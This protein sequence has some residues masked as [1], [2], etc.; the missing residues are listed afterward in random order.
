[1]T[2]IRDPNTQQGA[3][4]NTRGQLESASTVQDITALISEEDGEMY[5]LV[6]EYTTAQNDDEVIYLQN[7]SNKSLHIARII[8]AADI[9]SVVD[10]HKATGTPAGAGAIVPVNLS[11]SAGKTADVVALGNA[12]VTGLSTTA[13]TDFFLL[14]KTTYDL[15]YK[16]ALILAKNDAISVKYNSTGLIAVNIFFYFD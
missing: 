5:V 1:M 14:A 12:E 2:E 8:A 16:G 6:S 9:D 15:D 4:V 7:T 3:E 13:I 10:V 11:F